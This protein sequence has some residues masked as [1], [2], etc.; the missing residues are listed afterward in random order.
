MLLMELEG[1]PNT[2]PRVPIGFLNYPDGT[3][4]DLFVQAEQ[5]AE[6]A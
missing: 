3:G 5:T 4:V 6:D 2:P 1:E